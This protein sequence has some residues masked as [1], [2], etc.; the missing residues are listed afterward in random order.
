[1]A[2]GRGVDG[3]ERGDGAAAHPRVRPLAVR[4]VRPLAAVGLTKLDIEYLK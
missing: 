2:P 1:M 4:V 3:R